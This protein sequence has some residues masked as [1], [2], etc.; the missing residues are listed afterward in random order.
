MKFQQLKLLVYVVF[1]TGIFSL[2]WFLVIL[3]GSM[4]V[5]G[6]GQCVV[7]ECGPPPS[8]WE[9]YLFVFISL[10][11]PLAFCIYFYKYLA[12]KYVKHT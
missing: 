3:I 7:D 2:F 9:N 1:F 10:A 11:P 8:W 4:A 5:T 6:V 12:S